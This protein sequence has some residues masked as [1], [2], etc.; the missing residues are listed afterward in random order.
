MYRSDRPFSD[1]GIHRLA[2]EY[3]KAANHCQG[4]DLRQSIDQGVG[5]LEDLWPSEPVCP[6]YRLTSGYGPQCLNLSFK[7]F[8]F[9][10][11]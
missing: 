5:G 3:H 6:A 4:E 1:V 10:L 11:T 7:S 8:Y 9:F 2:E